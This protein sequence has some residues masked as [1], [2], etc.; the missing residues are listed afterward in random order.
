MSKK[1]EKKIILTQKLLLNT[2]DMKPGSSRKDSPFKEFQ[3]LES[4]PQFAS[5]NSNIKYNK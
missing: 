3:K 1:L 4:T 5:F 2:N